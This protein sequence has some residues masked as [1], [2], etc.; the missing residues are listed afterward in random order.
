MKN[1][2]GSCTLCCVLLEIREK[3][4]PPLERCPDCLMNICC[5]CYDE[6][7]EECKNFNCSWVLDGNAHA[8][9]RPDKCH[10]IFENLSE[11]IVFATLDP[12]HIIDDL[13]ISQ[14]KSFQRSGS[15][16]FLQTFKGKPQI[17]LAESATGK[18][19]HKLFRAKG[20]RSKQSVFF[21]HGSLF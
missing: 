16:V 20:L 17:H 10:I 5:T 8:D 15:S 3:N 9:L 12:N 18:Q 19:N 11:T 6:R 13:I 1:K 7:P 14:I 21:A 4:S 2:C